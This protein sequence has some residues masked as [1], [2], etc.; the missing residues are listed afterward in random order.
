[1]RRRPGPTSTSRRTV[2]TARSSTW[3]AVACTAPF[4]CSS[5]RSWPKRPRAWTSPW[6][7]TA[8]E[9]AAAARPQPARVLGD[10]Q[11]AHRRDPLAGR[12]RRHRQPLDRRRDRVQVPRRVHGPPPGRELADR[13]DEGGVPV[14][15]QFVGK[16]VCFGYEHR[17]R[18]VLVDR[19][20]QSK[21]GD[22][23]ITGL[24]ED[25]NDVRT[26]RVDRIIRGKVRVAK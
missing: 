12:G 5:S 26:F 4:R 6:R 11:G 20:W 3:R 10:V 17:Y 21:A 8:S 7:S 16:I 25:R 13:L 22:Q 9:L 23:L 15:E 2:V 18:L 24:D 1:T 19:V 14:M